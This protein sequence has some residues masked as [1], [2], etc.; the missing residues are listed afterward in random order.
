MSAAGNVRM[1]RSPRS[2]NSPVTTPTSPP[3]TSCHIAG[4]GGGE[5]G[6]SAVSSTPTPST[7][8]ASLTSASAAGQLANAGNAVSGSD[9]GPSVDSRGDTNTVTARKSPP[10]R[11]PFGRAVQSTDSVATSTP[12]AAANARQYSSQG[13]SPPCGGGPMISTNEGSLFDPLN[14][15]SQLICTEN[16]RNRISTS[17]VSVAR[18][19]ALPDENS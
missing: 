4:S 10:R 5:F 2:R 7:S 19:T 6:S 1:R 12:Y 11:T 9:G 15:F 14:F 17:I 3:N 8:T 13:R 18:P 16:D